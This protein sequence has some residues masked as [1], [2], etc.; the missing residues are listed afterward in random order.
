MDG[1]GDIMV[2][3]DIPWSITNCFVTMN[4]YRIKSTPDFNHLPLKMS[5]KTLLL[6]FLV[7]KNMYEV[8]MTNYAESYALGQQLSLSCS[9]HLVPR[10]YQGKLLILV[11]IVEERVNCMA[12][13]P[14]IT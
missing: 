5:T 14:A 3:T 11:L 7:V 4:M 12:I 1:M 10:A 6:N 13:I 2:C 9:G 8:S